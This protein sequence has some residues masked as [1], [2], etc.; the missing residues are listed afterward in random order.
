MA[1]RAL[2]AFDDDTAI[3]PAGPGRWRGEVSERWFVG[4]GPNGGLVAAQAVRA[5]EALVADPER[6]PRSL[7]VHYLEAPAAGPIELV[8]TVERE[9]RST[10]A[11]SLRIE[12]AG[13]TVAL[14]LGALALWRDGGLDHLDTAPPAVPLPDEAP[15]LRRSDEPTLPAFTD[16]YD[17]R[18]ATG[19]GATGARIGG[20]IR[21]PGGDRPVDHV[22]VAGFADAFPPAVFPL[23]EGR[24]AFAPTIDLTIHFRAPLERVGAGWVLAAFRSRRVAGG[25]F[26]EDGELWSEDG[27]LLA[28]SRQLAML[29]ER[30]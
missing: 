29:R 5:M 10:T 27:V 30:A 2:T 13:R 21:V 1:R 19:D 17:Y 3:V 9:G 7:T 11:V 4:R 26:E 14:A 12:Q 24:T 6:V 8:G 25:F 18:W 20:W 22:A 16:N 23:L 15:V 28:Q